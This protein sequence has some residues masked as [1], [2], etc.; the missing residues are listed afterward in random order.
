MTWL[1]SF[2]KLFLIF[3]AGVVLTVGSIIIEVT[4]DHS[5]TGSTIAVTLRLLGLAL[6]LVSPM[7]IALKFFAQLD[8]KAK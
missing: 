3:V 6:M 5:Y 2:V 8:R 4:L 7:L 1:P